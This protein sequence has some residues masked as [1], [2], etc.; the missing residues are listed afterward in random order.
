MKRP[1]LVTGPLTYLNYDGRRTVLPQG[2]CTFDDGP[3]R[4]GPY[5]LSWGPD[6]MPFAIDMC[7]MDLA[8]HV[9][10][11]VIA[12][13]QSREAGSITAKMVRLSVKHARR[14]QTAN[15]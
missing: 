12:N 10:N 3:R 9:A 7:L 14:P 11:G 2:P 1:M 6:E 4:T 8:R 13:R 5:I 15:G